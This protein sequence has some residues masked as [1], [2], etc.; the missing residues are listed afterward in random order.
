[1]IVKR[2]GW[3]LD[4]D[5]LTTFHRSHYNDLMRY[6]VR[7][8][9]AQD[10]DELTAEVFVIAWKKFPQELENPRPWLFGVARKVLSNAR[11]NSRRNSSFLSLDELEHTTNEPAVS[12]HTGAIA[13]H[14]DLK[15]AWNS[16]TES[17]REVLALTAWEGLTAAEVATA[18]GLRRST[19]AMRLARARERLRILIAHPSHERDTAV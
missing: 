7:R 15:R 1:M 4:D 8:G 16:L 13:F 2:G 18:L 11:R 17:E 5:L 3:G 6:F 10:A 12:T 14:V 9:A 19:V